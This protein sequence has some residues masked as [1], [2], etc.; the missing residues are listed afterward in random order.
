MALPVARK[1]IL[2][3]DVYISLNSFDGKTV[4]EAINQLLE[5]KNHL[6]DRYKVVSKIIVQDSGD[7]M[8]LNAFRLETDAEYASRLAALQK[9]E[10]I[11][12]E[13]E[14]HTLRRLQA[15]YPDVKFEL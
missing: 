8:H 11:S 10:D 14:L 12:R 7:G 2:V 5:A 3:G 15:K 6:L 4:T 13:R 1:S 9:A